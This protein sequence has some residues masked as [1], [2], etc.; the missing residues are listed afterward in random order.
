MRRPKAP[1]LVHP[2]PSRG[3][4]PDDRFKLVPAKLCNFLVRRLWRNLKLWVKDDATTSAG[5]GFLMH[6]HDRQ[7]GA[8]VQPGVG[9]GDRHLHSKAIDRDAW[10]ARMEGKID[11]NRDSPVPSK[12]L[13]EAHNRA[14]ALRHLVAGSLT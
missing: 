8:A 5:Q 4:L 10:L 12:R 3:I 9:E 1:I 6:R 11:Q 14:F 13:V 2:K 7:T